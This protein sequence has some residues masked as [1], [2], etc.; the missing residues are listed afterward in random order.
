MNVLSLD[1]H[2]LI[3]ILFLCDGLHCFDTDSTLIVACIFILVVVHC[4]LPHFH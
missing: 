4:S 2:T 1:V 3:M